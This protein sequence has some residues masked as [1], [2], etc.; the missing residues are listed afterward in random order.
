[1]KKLN[2]EKSQTYNDVRERGPERGDSQCSVPE[3]EG[4]T[5]K[6]QKEGHCSRR[7]VNEGQVS[8]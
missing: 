3:A 4:H 5:F 6:R 7:A 1:M 8:Q 2:S